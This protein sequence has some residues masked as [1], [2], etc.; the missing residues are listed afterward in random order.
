MN[1]T[2]DQVLWLANYFKRRHKEG[3]Q[4]VILPGLEKAIRES[5]VTREQL[6]RFIVDEQGLSNTKKKG[7]S[8]E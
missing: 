8:D 3:H 4:W 7:G 2:T 6:L 1:L 5:G